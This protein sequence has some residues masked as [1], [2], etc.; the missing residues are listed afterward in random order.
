MY[1]EKEE[2]ELT[3]LFARIKKHLKKYSFR[4]ADIDLLKHTL[5]EKCRLE[6]QVEDCSEHLN[7][8]YEEKKKAMAI[9]H[10]IK[11]FNI[12]LKELSE[13][14][15]HRYNAKYG[16]NGQWNSYFIS[17]ETYKILKDFGILYPANFD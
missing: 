12:N 4:N 6:K 3:E 7:C 14:G 8:V 10:T 15:L 5:K 16:Y 9:L 1:F 13:L 2:L 17:Y 11:F